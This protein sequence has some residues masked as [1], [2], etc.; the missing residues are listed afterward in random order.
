LK[1]GRVAAPRGF[2]HVSV[3]LFARC[4]IVNR[5]AWN[6]QFSAEIWGKTAFS[7]LRRLDIAQPFRII[8]NVE[9]ALSVSSRIIPDVWNPDMIRS[10]KH[11]ENVAP[12]RTRR[13]KAVVVG[14]GLDDP[15]GHVRYTRGDGFELY[16][17]SDSSHGEMQRLVRIINAEASRLGI[18]LEHMTYEQYEKLKAV[19]DSVNRG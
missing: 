1:A 14:L 19:V 10:V 11:D 4:G 13:G 15:E 12:S 8:H 6:S 16:G 2:A 7:A 17:G 9:S 18:C 3:I 5:Q